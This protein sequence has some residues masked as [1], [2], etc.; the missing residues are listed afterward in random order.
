M[1]SHMANQNKV[2]KE[3]LESFFRGHTAS[4]EQYREVEREEQLEGLHDEI[5]DEEGDRA[6]LQRS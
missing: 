5:G 3:E 6:R 1:W 2:K 4:W